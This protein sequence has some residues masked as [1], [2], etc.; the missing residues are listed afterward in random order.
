MID[1]TE[2]LDPTSVNDLS[3]REKEIVEDAQDVG[4]NPEFINTDRNSEG[5]LQQTVN[6]EAI[7]ADQ[8]GAAG[9]DSDFSGGVANLDETAG[10][11]VD[12]NEYND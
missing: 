10:K 6:P 5:A 2:L 1:K 9:G 3:K 12:E 4:N 7:K 8:T 11:I